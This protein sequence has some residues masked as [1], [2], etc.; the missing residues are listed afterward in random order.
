MNKFLLIT[1]IN[2]L[3][4]FNFFNKQSKFKSEKKKNI[5]KGIGVTLIIGYILFYVYFIANSLMPSF[6]AINK[7]LYLLAFLFSIC[8]IYIFFANLFKIK[9]IIFDFNDYDLLMSLP[10]KR[11]M[12]IVSKMVSL[13]IVNLLYTLIVMIPGYIAYI[14]YLNLPNDWLFFLLLLAIPIVPILASSI[15][16]IFIS[17]LTSFFK[18]KN[19]G[20]YAIYLL[21][22]IILV[23]GMYK[24]NGLDE[25]TLVNNSVNTVDK[26]SSYYP[27]TNIYIKLLNSFVIVSLLSFVFVPLTL[28]GI[29]IMFIN[30]GYTTLR[31]RLLRQNIKS[32]YK[33]TKY[34][35]NKP[36]VSLYK[37]EIKRFFSSPLYVLNT[38]FGCIMM[39]LLILIIIFFKE[40][41]IS[42]FTKLG[43]INAIIKNNIFMILSLMCVVS[44]TT[45]SS[46]SLEGKHL[47]II[48]MLPVSTSKIFI[49]KI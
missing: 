48:K 17:W 11:S 31:T 7:P 6:I 8:S 21:L 20:S 24:I 36:I 37:K 23:L 4:S 38:S 18:N 46:I 42:N 5:I 33:L 49:S 28:F 45:N 2:L 34:A 41:S 9:N 26:F 30:Y 39:F 29:F 47:W 44:S 13:Y 25:I 15:I 14:K 40:E 22:I 27:L 19:I 3:G 35:I 32:D 1:K 16:G 12:V 43:D 10:I